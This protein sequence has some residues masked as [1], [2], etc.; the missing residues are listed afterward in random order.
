MYQNE[1]YNAKLLTVSTSLNVPE[2]DIA[3]TKHVGLVQDFKVNDLF[4]WRIIT[5]S[6]NNYFVCTPR[7]MTQ[8]QSCSLFF[9]PLAAWHVVVEYAV[10]HCCVP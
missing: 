8:Q 9:Y 5:D 1:C 4:R 7:Q 6:F 2:D 10:R 3:S